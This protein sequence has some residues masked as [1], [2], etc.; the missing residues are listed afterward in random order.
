MTFDVAPTPKMLSACVRA[1]APGSAKA[2]A[3]EPTTFH[4]ASEPLD[5]AS[6]TMLPSGPP[7]DRSL[8]KP[9]IASLRI[10]AFAAWTSSPKGRTV[11]LRTS[12]ISNSGRSTVLSTSPS[13]PTVP[14]VPSWPGLASRRVVPSA[15]A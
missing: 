8:P 10:V 3:P 13:T 15:S 4:S 14:P 2:P 6:K 1:P 5:A 9:K 11:V 7:L 12:R